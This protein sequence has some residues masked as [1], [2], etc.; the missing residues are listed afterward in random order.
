[1]A[2]R[3]RRHRWR[4]V[5]RDGRLWLED[6]VD[7]ITKDRR[8]LMLTVG[9][10]VVV[11]ALAITTWEAFRAVGS[12]REAEHTADVLTDDIVHGDVDAARV[13]LAALDEDTSRAANSTNG[14]VWWL[15]AHIPIVGKN[16]D[17][18]RTAAR[19]IDQVTD[20]VLPGI[21]DVADQVRLETFRPK[22]GQVDL[23]AVAEAAPAI[24]RADE[25]LADANRDIAA[26]D[27]EGVIGPLRR[28]IAQLQ[29]RFATTATAA[30]AANDATKL[31]PT[32]LA[33]DGEKR[34]Y[35]LLIMNN[36]EVRSLGGMFGSIAEIT[37]RGGKVKMEEQGGIEDVLP[38][39]KSPI[40]LTETERRVLQSTVTTD[41]RDTG[42]IPHFPRAAELAAA[43]VG[44][45]WKERYD[46]VIAVDPVAMSYMLNAL[47][48][49]N[50]GDGETINSTNAVAT[51]LNGVYVKYPTNVVRQDEIFE[52]AARRI[53]DSLTG[54]RGD[55]VSAIRALV[56]GVDERRIMV[57][58]RDR[59][60][61]KRI[62]SGFLSG[63][64]E[65]GSGRPQVGVFVNDGAGSKMEF[66]LTMGT[67]VRSER[68][69]DNESQE[70]RVTTT[71]RNNAPANAGQLSI[72]VTGLGTLITR[73]HM[74]LPT[75]I[76]GPRGGTIVSMTVDGKPAPNGGAKY[77]GRP[78]ATVARQLP[79]GGST[80][81]VTTMRTPAF[82]PG[83]PELRTT[84]GVLPNEDVVEPSA[85]D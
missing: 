34:N 63:S 24:A 1:M 70:L 12:I 48:P 83:D 9:G 6:V 56:R 77:L 82:S 10:V 76:I 3:S 41:I 29:R 51:L 47:G 15:G 59:T 53:F 35:L 58:S 80:I 39:K 31:I 85:C 18:V 20:D 11:L 23:E 52:L 17:V 67:R 43:I 61:Q 49:V 37:A 13:T 40:E 75:L 4:R 8:R 21:V 68:C 84:P 65:T 14:P 44:K 42:L 45:R 64:L 78:V 19:E 7:A 60:E 62:Q 71:L 32:M 79:P 5:V 50:V 25:V 22:D 38:L 26:F 28:P 72:S 69:F 66:Y 36:A 57:W 33:A 30:A 46:G 74:M 27:V 16:V 81:I 54:G 55:S 73:G 2:P